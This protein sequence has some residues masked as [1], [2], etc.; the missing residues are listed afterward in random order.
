MCFPENVMSWG[1]E[2]HIAHNETSW[3][4]WPCTFTISCTDILHGPFE[5]VGHYLQS[6][7]EQGVNMVTSKAFWW[8]HQGSCS[9]HFSVS[10]R[11]A[12]RKVILVLC[13]HGN[14]RAWDMRCTA[15]CHECLSGVDGLQIRPNDIRNHMVACV[16]PENTQSIPTSGLLTP[17]QR[18][19]LGT[20]I[21]TSG[22]ATVTATD[23][24]VQR[25][26]LAWRWDSSTRHSL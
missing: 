18:L 21:R 25:L 13:G 9:S 12:L 17:G 3:G 4:R 1:G 6:D 20:L 8:H 26:G 14:L 19:L 2:S 22:E 10:L 16:R 24:E 15:G 5:C 7:R 11:G 23:T